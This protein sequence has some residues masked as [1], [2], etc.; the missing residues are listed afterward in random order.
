MHIIYC[1][2]AKLLIYISKL[3]LSIKNI[4][5]CQ[6]WS[7]NFVFIM[8]KKLSLVSTFD[9]SHKGSSSG[10]CWANLD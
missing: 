10:P 8:A 6:Y 1:E 9:C 3:I 7:S 5:K 4:F 2:L